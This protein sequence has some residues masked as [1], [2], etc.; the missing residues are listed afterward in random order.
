MT[1]TETY[2][3]RQKELRDMLA[4]GPNSDVEVNETRPIGSPS[5]DW[6]VAV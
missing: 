1:D 6:E 2:G 5:D 3:Q 4:K